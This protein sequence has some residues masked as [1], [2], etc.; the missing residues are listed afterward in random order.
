MKELTSISLRILTNAF[1]E[2]R[3]RNPSYSLR[4]FSRDLEISVSHLSAIMNGQKKLSTQQAGKIAIKLQLAP[5][6][7]IEL[8]T[9]TL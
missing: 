7:F 1:E 4:A 5:E 9:S 3:S 2:K 8:V 6:E